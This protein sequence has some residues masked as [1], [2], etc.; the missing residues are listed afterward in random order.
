MTIAAFG[1]VLLVL[2]AA[3]VIATGLPAYMALLLA[4]M[5]GAGAGLATGVVTVDLLGALPGRLFNLLENDLL[6][7]LPLY[8][9]MGAL[10]NRLGLSDA[11]FRTFSAV[12]GQSAAAPLVAG[13]GM[14]ALLGPMNGS[15]GASV[16]AM[17]RTVG[18]RLETAGVGASAREALI[19]VA[20]TLGVVVPPSLVLILLGDALLTAHT[21]ASNA[22]GRTARIINTQDLMRGALPAAALFVVGLIVVASVVGRRQT[23]RM[24]AL[25]SPDA[26]DVFT[27]AAALVVILGLLGG[28]A[29]GRFYA[30]EAAATGAV[31]LFCWALVGGRLRNGELGNV[32]SETLVSTGV[33]FA[34]L[35]AATTFTLVLRLLG[36]DK[37]VETFIMQIPGGPGLVLCLAL[38]S[39]A[40]AALALDAFEII[41]V[42]VPILAPP[43][44]MRVPDAVWVGVAMLLVLQTSFLL[45]PFGAALMLARASL[46]T[47]AK[48]AATVKSLV[49]YL[50]LQ[51]LVLALVLAAPRLVHVLDPMSVGSGTSV[52]LSPEAA[53]KRLREMMG[54]QSLPGLSTFPSLPPPPTLSR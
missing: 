11:L 15:V 13:V 20:G 33:L 35:L 44:L 54:G 32:M 40:I 37:L 51:M 5:V 21:I 28:V 26:R 23:R 4:A 17:S 8:L 14:G 52:I 48:L 29:A 45:P 42:V 31:L 24:A 19:A 34:P 38:A 27:T 9:L 6:Q 30:V 53:E 22:T 41:F 36:T 16:M 43:V 25:S 1:L 39:L 12:A 7:A 18:P 49:P 47:G 46:K 2:I 3:G 50:V 10:L